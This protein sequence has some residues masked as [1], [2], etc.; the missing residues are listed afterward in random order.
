MQ[1]ALSTKNPP[2]AR[3]LR[4]LGIDTKTEDRSTNTNIDAN[5]EDRLTNLN[6]NEQT[7]PPQE[8]FGLNPHAADVNPAS[9][10]GTK[11]CMK[12]TEELP[13]KEKLQVSIANCPSVKNHF[14][15]FC[16]KNSWVYLS[17]KSLMTMA[18]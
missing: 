16:S 1:S 17:E 15:N 2:A 12:E 13:T 5:S 7:A 9:S 18:A 3:E 4:A 11:C 8:V 14:E 6:M 10:D